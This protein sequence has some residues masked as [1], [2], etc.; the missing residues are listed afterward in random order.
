[1][2]QLVDVSPEV[3]E[4]LVENLS[5]VLEA[6]VALTVAY[7][8]K[9]GALRV[10]RNELFQHIG[11]NLACWAENGD[12]LCEVF[13]LSDISRPLVAFEYFLC[14]VV[15]D[16]ALHLVFLCHLHGK[17]AEQQHYVLTTL[18]QWR[19]VYRYRVESIVQVLAETSLADGLCHVHICCSHYAHV[20]LSHLCSSHRDIFSSLEYTQQSGLCGKRQFPHLVEE[21]R[22]L[23]CRT[24]ISGTVVDG[25]R[26]GTFHMSKQFAVYRSLGDGAA[27]DCEIFLAAAWRSFMNEA[28]DNLL[29]HSAFSNNEH[30]E[31]CRRH[32]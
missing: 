17:Q 19:H 16:Y 2:P 8:D 24:E 18:T 7:L 25:T 13:Q 3:E 15:E 12:L 27:V 32:L 29:S 30:T 1:M 4:N 26:E 22:S 14:S 10:L 23:V 6:V 11:G 31:V 5:L 20:G 21:Q 28:W 9:L